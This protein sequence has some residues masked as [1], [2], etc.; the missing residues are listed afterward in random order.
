MKKFIAY[1]LTSIVILGCCITLSHAVLFGQENFSDQTI[2]IGVIV[3]DLDASLDFYQNVIGMQKVRSFDVDAS[4]AASSGL[5][6]GVPF[7]VEVLQLGTKNTATE[8]KLMSFGDR[9]ETAKDDFIYGHT[10]PQ[11]IT[12]M[13]DNLTPVYNRMKKHNIQALGET[14]VPL[15]EQNSFILV[16]DPDG[17]FIELIGPMK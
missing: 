9:A 15:D 6:N 16:Q 17:V 3:S 11:Y 4:F 14:P 10:G 7:H 2:D 12:I 5:S 1:F 8:Y 13:V